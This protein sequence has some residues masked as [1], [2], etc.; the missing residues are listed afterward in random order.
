MAAAHFLS[1]VIVPDVLGVFVTW[2]SY[3]G[4]PGGPPSSSGI[5]Y[6]ALTAGHSGRLQPPDLAI[7]VFVLLQEVA[8]VTI[9]ELIVGRPVVGA[10]SVDGCQSRASGAAH[11][12]HL[13]TGVRAGHQAL[14]ITYTWRV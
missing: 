7:L 6:S 3:A 1:V 13:W 2:H 11:H 4:A 8:S 12:L 5:W 10:N 9:C 14:P